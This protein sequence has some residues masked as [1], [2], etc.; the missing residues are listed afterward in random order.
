[1][2]ADAVSAGHKLGQM[3]GNFFEE[4]FGES[5]TAFARARNL[6]CDR[7]GPRPAIRGDKQKVTWLDREGNAHDLDY[8]LE[9]GGNE[10]QQGKPVAFIE[11]AWRRYTKHSRNKSG[12]LEA[13]LLHLRRTHKS[14]RFVGALLVGE[15]SAGGLQQLRSHQIVVLHIPFAR[16]A[17]AF[18]TQGVELAYPETAPDT[19]KRQLIAQCEALAPKQWKKIKQALRADSKEDWAAFLTALETALARAIEE[20][21]IVSLYGEELAC[22]S[23]L[24]GIAW[25]AGYETNAQRP[26]RHHRFEI[27]VR[28]RNGSEAEGAFVTKAEALDFL[29]LFE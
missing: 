15:Y 27:Q 10:S 13:S 22:A 28:F 26:L 3:I 6:Y 23:L 7:K 1:M 2:K 25:L 9:A 20:V 21:R 29:C 18:R 5:L 11:L 8:V 19:V 14:C 16:I 4:F 17:A 24:E 12:E